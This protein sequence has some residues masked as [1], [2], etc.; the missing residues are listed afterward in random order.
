MPGSRT[1][2]DIIRELNLARQA[3]QDAEAAVIFAK[4]DTTAA[5]QAYEEAFE[6]VM[7]LERELDES[8]ADGAF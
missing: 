6:R 4:A 2:A 8:V 3:R 1:Q 7:Q 5:I